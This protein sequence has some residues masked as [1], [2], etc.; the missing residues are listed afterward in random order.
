MGFIF[1]SN[2]DTYNTFGNMTFRNSQGK[3]D[4]INHSGSMSFCGDGTR[5][6]S[7]NMSFFGGKSITKSGNTYFCNGNTYQRSGNTLFG[8]KGE[9]WNGD[10]SDRDIR[11]IISHDN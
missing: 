4:T 8:S 3:S 9:T 11:D 1:G 2:G 5:L 6:D 10:M 7:G